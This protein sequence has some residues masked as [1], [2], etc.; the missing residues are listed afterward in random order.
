MASCLIWVGS[1][2]SA[3]SGIPTT[4]GNGEGSGSLGPAGSP[5]RPPSP[6][7]SRSS[8]WI[9][10]GSPPPLP[11]P[12]KWGPSV[13]V[14]G[15]PSGDPHSI[16][17]HQSGIVNGISALA[18]APAGAGRRGGVGPGGWRHRRISGVPPARNFHSFVPNS[19]FIIQN[20]ARGRDDGI[21]K[22]ESS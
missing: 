22:T 16:K 9:E 11:G 1:S 14:A 15:A 3:L 18:G 13:P 19:E 2:K 12:G 21:L 6:S 10:F 20:S 17:N 7:P 4:N 8:W 5:R